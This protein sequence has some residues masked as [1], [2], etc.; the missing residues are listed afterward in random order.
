MLLSRVNQAITR[1]NIQSNIISIRSFPFAQH[2]DKQQLNL[3]FK[4]DRTYIQ[5]GD[6]YNVV[7]RLV[8][9]KRCRV[10]SFLSGISPFRPAGLRPGVR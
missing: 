6:I 1:A 3:K 8:R 10:V 5:G 4:G 7:D 2:V 9:G